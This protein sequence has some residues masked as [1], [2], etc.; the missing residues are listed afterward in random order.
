MTN[1]FKPA[2]RLFAMLLLIFLGACAPIAQPQ[3]AAPA[4]QRSIVLSFD[5]VPRNRGPWFSPEERTRR[6]IAALAEAD[7][8]Q[9]AFFVTTANLD[10][11]DGAGGEAR[12]AAYVRAGHVIANHSHT[13]RALSGM[14][15]DEYLA[16]IDR[17]EQW[18]RGR[19]GYR[20]WFRF[21]F[22]NEGR[23]D[24]A[25]RDAVFTGLTAR[26]LRHGF[27]TVD[28]SDW[29]LEALATEAERAGLPVNRDALRDLY[30]ESHV[31]AAEVYDR[32]LAQT[33]HR[34]ATHVMLLHETDIAALWIGDLVTALR[35]HGWRIV[36]AD[37]GFA[38]PLGQVVPRV[39]SGQGPI[40]ELLA[41]E[42]GLPAP[43]WYE[44]N[45]MPVM[46]SLFEARA[47][48]GTALPAPPG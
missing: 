46:R 37:E 31:E 23:A 1:Y 13:H 29:H 8:R 32:L 45:R 4:A 6:L 40:S 28:A 42:A 24:A 26:G 21:P 16:D 48:G 22:L 39:P 7:V 10:Q 30:V 11:P 33:A 19:P 5:D 44:R 47:L 20:P 43:R 25:K 35:A 9:A 3:T 15:A 36:T 14:T 12:I 34:G 41:W 27:V 2:E 17:A 18:L 38:G